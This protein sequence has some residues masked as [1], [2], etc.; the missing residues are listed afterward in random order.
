MKALFRGE[1][2]LGGEF[3]PPM[4]GPLLPPPVSPGGPPIWIGGASEKAVVN[5]AEIADGWN[6][7]GLAPDVFAER[8]NL[9]AAR[10]PAVEA[11][12]SGLALVGKDEADIA[13]LREARRA[14]NRLDKD[15]WTGTAAEL[16]EHLGR[17]RNDGRATWAILL[18]AGPADR[19]ELVAEAVLP[20][21]AA[22]S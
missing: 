8:A 19:V 21:V 16:A 11:T 10:N 14:E 12:W 2:W 3:V 20:E 18:V 13:R 5:A 7:W 4:A 1:A 22:A 17:L 15:L 6:G 9:L